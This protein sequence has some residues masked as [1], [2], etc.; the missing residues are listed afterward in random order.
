LT[1]V[2]PNEAAL[3]ARALQ[4]VADWGAASRLPDLD[5]R[6]HSPLRTTAGRAEL[7]RRRILLN[8]RLLARAPEQI[9]PV[10][11]HEAAHLVVWALHGARARPHGPEWSALMARAG[12][13]ARIHHRIPITGL[14]RRRFWYLHLCDRCGARWILRRALR[15]RCD[16]CRSSAILK[17]RA[18][19]SRAGL[20]AL[21]RMSVADARR[22]C[23]AP[24]RRHAR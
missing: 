18:A 10:L 8:P 3:R 11:L 2:L 6:W 16:G 24:P 19:R 12:L 9:E 15:L 4:A 7:R 5:V 14:A 21:A 22:R 1:A 17:L 13:P 23:A 20:D